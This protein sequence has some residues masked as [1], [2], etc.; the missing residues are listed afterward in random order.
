MQQ[1]RNFLR[2][3]KTLST[4]VHEVATVCVLIAIL[5]LKFSST[6]PVLPFFQN[7]KG[8]HARAYTKKVENILTAPIL[9]FLNVNSQNYE[10]RRCLFRREK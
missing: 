6:M 7:L 8:R 9:R 5:A 2:D 1:Y 10:S 4:V 3:R